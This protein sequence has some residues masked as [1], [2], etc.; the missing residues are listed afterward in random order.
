MLRRAPT[1]LEL[2]TADVAEFEELMAQR[3]AEKSEDDVARKAVS[4]SG[5]WPVSHVTCFL[6]ENTLR[7]RRSPL[8]EAGVQ[9][10]SLPTDT[11]RKTMA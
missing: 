10:S 9:V 4:A 8:D 3:Q 5:R 6:R 11:R 1:R 7:Q 2:T